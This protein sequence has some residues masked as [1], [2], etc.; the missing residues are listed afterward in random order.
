MMVAMLQKFSSSQGTLDQGPSK[1]AADMFDMVTGVTV[2]RSIR[3][4]GH[5]A[6]GCRRRVPK[7]GNSAYSKIPYET[8]NE[9]TTKR[10][11]K[12]SANNNIPEPDKRSSR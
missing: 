9:N 8:N 12:N 2:P 7:Q 5:S 11:D 6:R 1:W 3:R 10:D 4:T